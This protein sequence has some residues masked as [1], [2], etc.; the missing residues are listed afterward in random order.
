MIPKRRGLRLRKITVNYLRHKTN[1]DKWL[2]ARKPGVRQKRRMLALAVSFGVQTAMSCHT[3]K[4]ADDIYQQ[5]AGGS[6][7]LELT[8]AVSR[9]FMLRWDQLY[10]ANIKKAGLNLTMYERYVDDSNQVAV[11]PP[12]GAKYDVDTKKVVIDE[13]LI[14]IAE[15]EDER[16][17]RVFTDIANNVLPGIIMEFDVPSR[18]ANSKIPIIDMEVWMDEQTGDILFHQL[19]PVNHM[20]EQCPYSGNTT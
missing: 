16:T 20:Q 13:T 2:P 1:A 18:N 12:P 19:C 3:Y 5:M 10:R 9:P 8:G 4:I 15:C 11:V 14:D 17:A 7:G 6:I